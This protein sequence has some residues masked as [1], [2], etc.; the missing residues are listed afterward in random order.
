MPGCPASPGVKPGLTVGTGPDLS[1]RAAPRRWREG[2]PDG[3]VPSGCRWSGSGG[4]STLG[5]SR[6]GASRFA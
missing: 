5:S 3:I 4:F 1:L 6:A 2:R